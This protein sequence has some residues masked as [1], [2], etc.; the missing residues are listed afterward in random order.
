LKRRQEEDS[1]GVAKF[2]ND[3]E[4]VLIETNS[5]GTTQAAYTLEPQQYG[6]LLSQR[7]SG[8]SHFH[9]FDVIGSTDS[10]TNAAETKEVHYQSKAFGP[11]EV[12]S[13]SFAANRLTWNARVGYRWE[14]DTQQYD[15]RR[16]KYRAGKIE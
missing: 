4:N 7:R 10:V 14:P 16:R 2:I 9:H 13:G 15:V 1:A 8:A 3:M 6:N 12:L 11:T 5:G